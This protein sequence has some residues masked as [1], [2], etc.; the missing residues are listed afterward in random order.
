MH[1]AGGAAVRLLCMLTDGQWRAIIKSN[2][3]GV[4]GDGINT[5]S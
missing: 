1:M 4:T 3:R 2:Y 5:K